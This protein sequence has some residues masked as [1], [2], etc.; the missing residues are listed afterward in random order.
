M[1]FEL[2]R[3]KFETQTGKVLKEASF[4]KHTSN[5][6]IVGF[7]DAESAFDDWLVFVEKK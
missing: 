5:V 6:L 1:L 2:L 3:Q 7:V 4:A